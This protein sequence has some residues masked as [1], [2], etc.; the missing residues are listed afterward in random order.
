MNSVMKVSKGICA[1]LPIDITMLQKD[2]WTLCY[3]IRA[4]HPQ[5]CYLTTMC[6]T[7]APFVHQLNV[8]LQ[9][10]EKTWV[11]ILSYLGPSP[12]LLTICEIDPY[13]FAC[14]IWKLNYQFQNLVSLYQTVP[15]FIYSNWLLWCFILS[16]QGYVVF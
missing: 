11:P 16:R 14:V 8:L 12:I 15:F 10:S 2:T 7:T 4:P 6:F 1:W 3:Q 9:T 13:S 5:L